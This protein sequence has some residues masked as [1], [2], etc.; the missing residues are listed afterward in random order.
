MLNQIICNN[1]FIRVNKSSVFFLQVGKKI[2]IENF[3]PMKFPPMK[4]FLKCSYR[5]TK[6]RVNSITAFYLQDM[7]NYA[8]TGMSCTLNGIIPP[9]CNRKLTGKTIYN[10]QLNLEHFLSPYKYTNIIL[11][12]TKKKQQ[13]D[14]PLIRMHSIYLWNIHLLNPYEVKLQSSTKLGNI[15]PEQNKVIYGVSNLLKTLIQE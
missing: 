10:T 1:Q 8:K 5:K 2:D 11:Y 9:S 13:P 6:S 7:E 14:C 3:L 4:C 12:E 15:S